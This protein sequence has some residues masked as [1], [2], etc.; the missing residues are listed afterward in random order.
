MKQCEFKPGDLIL[1]EG[2]PSDVVYETISG[3][4]EIFTKLEDRTIIL[5]TVKAG[6]F[7]GEMGIIEHRPRNA[8]ARAKTQVAA[9]R[10]EKGE[11]LKLMSDNPSSA[12]RLIIRLSERLRALN[13][14]L[15]EAALSEQTATYTIE[16]APPESLSLSLPIATESNQA[17]EDVRITLLSSS[18][19]V[20][21]HM[22]QEE[23]P[24]KK[25]PFSVGRR[26]LERERPSSVPIDLSLPDAPPFRLSRQHFAL[27]HHGDGYV[28]LDLG[29]TL[30]TE[31][32]GDFLGEHFDK[33]VKYLNMGENT[34]TAG[35]MESPFTFIV[36]LEKA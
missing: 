21:R 4:V 27:G 10:L 16:N 34:I 36:R 11:F 25:F 5:G 17:I 14:K 9:L 20:V 28:V 15:T 29:S 7:L 1:Q 22:P 23:L 13:K 24:V 18:P 8:S 31:V 6:E 32:N 26:P 30:G 19:Y 12:H 2:D 35:G 33:D 3:E